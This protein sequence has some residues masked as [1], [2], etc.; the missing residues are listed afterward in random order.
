M[1]LHISILVLI[2]SSVKVFSQAEFSDSL[3][4]RKK[5]LLGKYVPA[6]EGEFLYKS[7]MIDPV[8]MLKKL[9]EFR[10]AANHAIDKDPDSSKRPLMRKDV[11]FFYRN[12]LSD[13]RIYYGV[14]SFKQANFYAFMEQRSRLPDFKG[15][16]DSAYKA[17]YVKSLSPPDKKLLDS[18]IFKNWEMND[19]ELF[20][21]SGA[22]RRAVNQQIDQ[23]MYTEYKKEFSAGV[24]REKIREQIID[25]KVTSPELKEYF[26]YVQTGDAIKMSEDT[27]VLE[28]AYRKFISTSTN[29][30]YVAAIQQL[31]DNYKKY[32]D[33]GIAPDFKY[34]SIN[35]D[36]VS[37]SGLNGKYVYID[38]WATWCGPCKAEIPFL[39]E[40]EEKYKGKNIHFVSISVDQLS[41][42]S[43]WEQYVTEK[44]LKGIQLITDNAFDADFIKKFNIN[45]IPRFILIDPAG[46]IVSGNALRPSD[47][48][49]KQQLDKLL[50]I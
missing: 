39:T 33:N 14:D 13:Y 16:I 45:S 48:A 31:Y 35:N 46:K 40:I 5:A 21:L 6:K 26:N 12:L 3:F 18:L 44:K 50:G 17:M 29:K 42:K 49:L 9:E 7:Y 37:L 11:D 36:L 47:P 4:P 25:K 41:D 38:I 22:Y 30:K 20:Q 24:S 27:A 19:W 32:G 10:S 15:K 43:K 28:T 8:T 34:R 1:K 2:L 23:Y